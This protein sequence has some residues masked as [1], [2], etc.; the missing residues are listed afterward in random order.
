MS[1]VFV[2]RSLL[3]YVKQKKQSGAKSHSFVGACQSPPPPP[4]WR[5]RISQSITSRGASWPRPSSLSSRVEI[6]MEELKKKRRI[7]KQ[8]GTLELFLLPEA[9]FFPRENYLL[10]LRDSSSLPSGDLFSANDAGLGSL[11]F[12]LLPWRPA[13]GV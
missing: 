2:L 7:G 10:V 13:G 4:E 12:Y 8:G 1:F 9:L 6:V 3:F 11:H 5:Q